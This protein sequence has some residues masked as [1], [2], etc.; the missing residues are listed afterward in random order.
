MKNW[1]TYLLASVL[2]ALFFLVF[3]TEAWFG[4]LV[5]TAVSVI[6][7]FC[8]AAFPVTVFF[9]LCA[10][11]ASFASRRDIG[12]KT[13]L[14]TVVWGLAS[15]LLLCLAATAFNR[16]FPNTI[17]TG[18]AVALGTPTLSRL[19][20]AAI[21]ALV[22]GFALRPTSKIFNE[23]Y[24]LSN[25][26]SE[27]VFRLCKDVSRIWWI[28]VFFL[29]AKQAPAIPTMGL[30]AVCLTVV[31]A[32]GLLPLLYCVF[33]GFRVNPYKKI[34]RLLPALVPAFFGASAEAAF[35]PLYVCERNNLGIQK[36]VAALTIPLGRIFSRG[37]TLAV[38]V[39]AGS[40]P[41]AIFLLPLLAPAGALL[42]VLCTGLGASVCAK[43]TKADCE[44]CR[45]DLI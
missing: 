31:C 36:R 8:T 24:K 44:I 43:L 14:F 35:I 21:T 20:L 15:S 42:D 1:L 33:T 41:R 19:A 12:G 39:L 40:N 4:P 13:L 5:D 34:I 25:S 30:A 16:L 45:E 28:A 27:V 7:K 10:A 32:S 22:L 29:S 9:T 23:A 18:S 37:G 26:L 38:A 6:V 11:T 17:D 2:G 3:G